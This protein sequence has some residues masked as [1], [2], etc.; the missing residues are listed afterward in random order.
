MTGDL[1]CYLRTV[2]MTGE[3]PPHERLARQLVEGRVGGVRVDER[4]LAAKILIEDAEERELDDDAFNARW[5]RWEK[6]GLC[7]Q[8][9]HSVVKCALGWACWKTYLGRPE[10]DWAR[11]MAMSVLGNGL[12]AAER[13]ED[14]LVVQEAE[15]AMVRRLDDSEGA[16][17]V[18]QNNLAGTYQMLGRHEEAMCARKDVYSGRLKLNGEEH[19]MTLIAAE[20]YANSLVDLGR[21]QEARSLMRRTMPVARRVFGDSKEDTLKMRGHYAKALYLDAGAMLDDLR[22]AVT[23]LEDSERTVRRVFGGAHPT[24]VDIERSLR[25]ARAALAVREA[26]AVRVAECDSLQRDND[27]LERRLELLAA[28]E[29]AEAVQVAELDA[30]RRDCEAIKLRLDA[31]QARIAALDARGAEAIGK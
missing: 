17:L 11:R 6:C 10:A 18:V 25:A 23:T 19:P 9:Y 29:A 27:A 14:A 8:K 1:V 22:E 20:G 30:C 26:E 5:G 2:T 13:F 4:G 3:P 7:E 21:F 28:H 12:D 31:T 24:A 15:L 16:I